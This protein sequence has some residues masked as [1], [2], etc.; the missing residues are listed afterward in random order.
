MA[1]FL[2]QLLNLSSVPILCKSLAER[3]FS[4]MMNQFVLK[5]VVHTRN[6]RSLRTW[7][8]GP[9]SLLFHIPQTAAICSSPTASSFF[10]GLVWPWPG[11]VFSLQTVYG[12]LIPLADNSDVTGLAV[13]ILNRLLWNPDIAA[14]YR[15][16]S[17]P[18]LF[19]DGKYLRTLCKMPCPHLSR[20]AFYF[21]NLT[22]FSFTLIPCFSSITI[23]NSCL[24]HPLTHPSV[25]YVLW[26]LHLF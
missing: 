21:F 3:K 2:K 25:L 23:Y 20:F 7:L 5:S 13:F 26:G 4:Q 10:S 24:L 22:G 1:C 6:A 18:L 9:V 11:L 16:P 8:S 15:H 19:R 17:V 14:E 12:E